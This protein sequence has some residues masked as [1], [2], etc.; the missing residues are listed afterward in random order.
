MKER[1]WE[2]REREREKTKWNGGETITKVHVIWNG[3]ESALQWSCCCCYWKNNWRRAGK[4]FY[5]ILWC[6]RRRITFF[7]WKTRIQLKLTKLFSLNASLCLQN[8]Q[9]HLICNATYI[10]NGA[11]DSQ[12]VC[13]AWA[14]QRRLVYIDPLGRFHA[15]IVC[16]HSHST[17]KQEK[18]ERYYI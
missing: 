15:C 3:C 13:C 16:A 2:S 8:V 17:L 11:N 12:R 6:K 1:T 4:S 10:V 18:K 9:H 14:R 5:C 7:W